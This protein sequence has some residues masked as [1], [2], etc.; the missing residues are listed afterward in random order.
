MDALQDGLCHICRTYP[1]DSYEWH[2]ALCFRG[3]DPDSDEADA[4]RSGWLR[5]LDAAQRRLR[6]ATG[7][8]LD[9][10]RELH[11]DPKEEKA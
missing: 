2:F 9:L 4:F 11:L 7:L 1:E 6:E 8:D 5:A 3:G 10:G